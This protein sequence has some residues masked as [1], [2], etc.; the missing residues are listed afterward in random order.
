LLS[1]LSCLFFFFLPSHR[2][3]NL[4]HGYLPPIDIHPSFLLTSKFWFMFFPSPCIESSSQDPLSFLPFL[5]PQVLQKC[6][7]RLFLSSPPFPPLFLRERWR[8]FSF[9]GAGWLL[10]ISL[11]GRGFFF[12]FPRREL[13]TPYRC[14]FFMRFPPLSPNPFLDPFVK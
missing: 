11:L 6:L 1:P 4:Y 8:R 13:M 12:P 10:L 2:R 7:R 3:S 14:P 9:D 5:L